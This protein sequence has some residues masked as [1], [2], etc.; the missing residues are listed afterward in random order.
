MTTS[1]SE[2]VLK[3]YGVLRLFRINLWLYISPLTARMM[4]SSA[5]VRGW[6]PLSGHASVHMLSKAVGAQR[7][8]AHDAQTLM[9]QDCRKKLE[10]LRYSL[11]RIYILG[12]HTCVLADDASACRTLNV[13]LLRRAKENPCDSVLTPI[14]SSVP[15]AAATM[16]IE[17]LLN[18]ERKHIR[19]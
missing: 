19:F 8:D 12:V 16:S 9:A 4:L 11:K 3:W 14:G 7:T 6:A 18:Q 2:C 1:Q 13:S 17:L 10:G 15:D 5:L